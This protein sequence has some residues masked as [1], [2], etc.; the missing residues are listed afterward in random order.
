ML[1]QA[2]GA[3]VKSLRLVRLGYDWAWQLSTGQGFIYYN[4]DF[5]KKNDDFGARYAV[6]LARHY[7]GIE[8][9]APV[10]EIQTE[11]SLSYPPINRLLPVYKVS[12]G[13]HHGL[14]AYVDPASDRLGSLSDSVRRTAL[15]LF[16]NIHTLS[17]LDPAEAVRVMVIFL[18]VGSILAMAVLGSLMRSRMKYRK[19]GA[20][21]RRAHGRCRRAAGAANLRPRQRG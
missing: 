9:T 7:T 15:W 11:F 1:E 4:A 10:T 18:S 21:P 20:Q 5:G 14:T 19:Q 13:A 16:Q 2:Q 17:F 12:Y 8:V 3:D 6:D